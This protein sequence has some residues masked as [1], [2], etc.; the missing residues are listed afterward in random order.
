MLVGV[1]GNS[2]KWRVGLEMNA[3]AQISK[4]SV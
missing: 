2:R 4:I 3:H 1:V